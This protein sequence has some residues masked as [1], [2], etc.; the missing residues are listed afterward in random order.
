RI[1]V[2]VRTTDNQ[3]TEDP[4]DPTAG[5]K[6][7]GFYDDEGLGAS[8]DDAVIAALKRVLDPSNSEEQA[9][10]HEIGRRLFLGVPHS[11]EPLSEYKVKEYLSLAFPWL[12][13]YHRGYFDT[14]GETKRPVPMS[15]EVYAE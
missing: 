8:D 2:D 14:T 3:S 15:L 11:K 13:P 4:K 1:R 6:F 9:T 7:S 5:Y 10:W 12:Y